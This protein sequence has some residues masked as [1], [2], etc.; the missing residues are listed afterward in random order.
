MAT[1]VAAG[2]ILGAVTWFFLEQ[3]LW[4]YARED[5]LSNWAGGGGAMLVFLF[6]VFAPKPGNAGT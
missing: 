1:R 6:C 2:I 4:D 5:W 3:Y